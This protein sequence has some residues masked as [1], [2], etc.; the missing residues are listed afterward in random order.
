MSLSFCSRFLNIDVD[1]LDRFGPLWCIQ[2]R[3]ASAA[4]PLNEVQQKLGSGSEAA[5]SDGARERSVDRDLEQKR[6]RPTGGSNR[7]NSIASRARLE[8]QV[9]LLSAQAAQVQAAV[10][11]LVLKTS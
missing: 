7:V 8:E 4:I 6:K 2:N 11:Q 5:A 1:L 3:D 10:Q 9:D